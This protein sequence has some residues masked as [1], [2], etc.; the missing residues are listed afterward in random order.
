MSILATSLLVLGSIRDTVQL[1]SPLAIHT[2]PAPY[3]MLCGWLLS[4]GVSLTI[5]F[6]CGSI[7]AIFEGSAGIG[8][9]CATQTDPAATIIPTAPPTSILLT[10]RF[11]LVSTR[12]TKP[13]SVSV[14]HRVS[15]SMAMS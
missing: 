5:S 3:T 7:R 14:I 1:P 15:P 9:I 4:S 8:P 13:R 10:T 2:L 11:S 6:V 12:A